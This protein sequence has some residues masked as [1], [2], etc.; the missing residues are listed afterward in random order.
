MLLFAVVLFVVFM[1][2]FLM[3]PRSIQDRVLVF[4]Q[5]DDFMKK[6]QEAFNETNIKSL[7]MHETML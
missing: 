2:I 4:V 7:I 3:N 5:Y 1:C 6:V